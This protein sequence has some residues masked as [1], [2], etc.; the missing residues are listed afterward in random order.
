ML[1]Q[2]SDL[3]APPPKIDVLLRGR[4]IRGVRV[5][6][7]NMENCYELSV[8]I[9]PEAVGFGTYLLLIVEQGSSKVLSR[10]VL[11]DGD[12]NGEDLRAE[13]VELRAEID[14]LK[15]LFRTSRKSDF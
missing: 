2:T 12:L 9:P 3:K 14:L 8:P 11:L 4:P 1:N 15:R 13:M 10:I 7:L 5:D 6:P